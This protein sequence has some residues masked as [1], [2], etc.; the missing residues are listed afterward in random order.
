MS[1]SYKHTPISKA[2]GPYGNAKRMAS[3]AARRKMAMEEPVKKSNFYKKLYDSWDIYDCISYCPE[4]D[5]EWWF[6]HC[7]RK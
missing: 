3:K 1:R 4:R 2:Y 5:K 6:K 7:R